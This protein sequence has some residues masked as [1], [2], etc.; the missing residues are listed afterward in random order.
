MKKQGFVSK[1]H[2][3]KSHLKPTSKHIQKSNLGKSVIRSRLE[4]F[5]LT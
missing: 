2:R 4:H 1:I 3:R 5:L